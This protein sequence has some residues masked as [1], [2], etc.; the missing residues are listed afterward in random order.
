MCTIVHVN[1]E[2]LQLST[3]RVNGE[4]WSELPDD[5][6]DGC[7]CHVDVDAILNR[8]KVYHYTDE[9]GDV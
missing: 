9:I 3:C 7:L 5:W 8:A 4:P 2:Q 1:A 6:R